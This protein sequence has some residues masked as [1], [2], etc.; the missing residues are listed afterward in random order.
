MR[1]AAE[2]VEVIA[3]ELEAR[4]PVR[5][6]RAA[7][8]AAL[9]AAIALR[10]FDGRDCVF[11]LVVVDRCYLLNPQLFFE[12]ADGG[13]GYFAMKHCQQKSIKNPFHAG[14]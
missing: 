14:A 2:A 6:E 8:E 13:H 11:Y 12:R 7:H 9:H 1:A 3:V 10:R 5:V 4:R